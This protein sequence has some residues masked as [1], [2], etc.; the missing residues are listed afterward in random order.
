MSES[1][2][3]DEQELRERLDL[4]PAAAR[5][6]QLL[7]EVSSA[8]DWLALFSP[9]N[10]AEARRDFLSGG[11][12]CEPDFEYRPL[13]TDLDRLRGRLDEAPVSEVEETGLRS[14]MLEKRQELTA[15]IHLVERR[16]TEDALGL[17]VSVFGEA[18]ALLVDLAEEIIERCNAQSSSSDCAR[19]SGED[20]L[21]A[22]RQH[23]DAYRE[24]CSEFPEAAVLS[25]EAS[26]LVVHRGVLTIPRALSISERRVQPL[27]HHEVGIHVLTWH[28]GSHQPIQLLREGLAGYDALQEG[29]GVLAEYLVG[30][31]TVAR[32]RL[33]AARVLAVRGLVRGDGFRDVFRVLVADAGMPESSAF[34]V[35]ARVF[36]GGGLTKDAVYLAG[37]RDLL[38]YLGR[39]R[40]FECLLIGKIALEHADRINDLLDE[41]VL[42]PPC[43]LPLYL[44][45]R[46][47]GDY[48]AA[49]A[50]RKLE[51]CR[52]LTVA[53][54]AEEAL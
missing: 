34:G 14:L 39:D 22:A 25:D 16:N 32:L 36:R 47:A 35:A 3:P 19:V 27:L 18:E 11:C 30:G 1:G 10:L 8:L 28:N 40:P 37:L 20:L 4:S 2:P 42:A 48:G 13:E 44:S 52:R 6:D 17:S 7:V 21:V 12:S 33:V 46:T 43:Q 29:L 31:L 26:G 49:Q 5:C 23:F 45:E 53:D 38:A 41:G 51:S 15:L 24:G 50:R 54:L 9:V